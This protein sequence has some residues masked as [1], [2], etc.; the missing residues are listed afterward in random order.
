MRTTSIA[1]ARALTAAQLRELRRELE[2]ERARLA[3]TD[4]RLDAYGDAL[5]RMD[6]G[7]YGDCAHC[8]ERIPFERLSV[9]P[10]TPVCINCR[11]YA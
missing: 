1:P 9:M 4:G 6:E 10:E 8:R 7:T 2:R 3:P 11:G 5:R